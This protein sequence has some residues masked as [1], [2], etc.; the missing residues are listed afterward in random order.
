LRT[1]GTSNSTENRITNCL[2]ITVASSGLGHV[3][4]GVEA[5]ANDLAEALDARGAAVTLC[6]GGGTVERPYEKVISCWQRESSRTKRLLEVMPRR[7]FWRVGLSSRYGVEQVTFTCNLITHLRRARADILHVQDPLVAL[8]VQRA[9]QLRLVRTKV[10]LA[11]G[12]EEPP[13]FL[14]KIT[15]LQHLAPWHLETARQAGCWK[16]T[17][18]AIPNFIDTDRF[19]P[20]QADSLREELGI[21]EGALVVLSVAAMR[22]I[23]KRVDY[24]IQEMVRLRREHPALPVWLVVAGGWEPATDELVAEG[25]RLLG[26]RVRFL[27]RF[28]R[29]RMPE[30]YRI[31]SVFTLCSLKEMLG[32]VLLEAAATSLPCIIHRHPVMEWVVGPGGQSIDMSQ[33]GALAK[34]LAELLQRPE[35]LCALGNA[36]RRHCVANFATAPVVDRIL[37]Y[38]QAVAKRRRA[39]AAGKPERFPCP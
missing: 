27:V 39:S 4:R 18:T 34:T 22:R 3:A 29:S 35:Q 26:D 24:L 31:A 25:Q 1:L 16:Q 9:R 8:L 20:G 32:I 36:A 6:K 11:D 10:I 2:N 30:L 17:W 13:E 28:P 15:Y 19:S 38:Y 23:H 33:S 37:D 12:T 5:W 14:R 7:L 21:P